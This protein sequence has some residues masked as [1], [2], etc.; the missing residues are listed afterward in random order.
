MADNLFHTLFNNT[1]FSPQVK[2]EPTIKPVVITDEP[3]IA[4][5]AP[6][7]AINELQQTCHHK[8]TPTKFISGTPVVWFCKTCKLIKKLTGETQLELTNRSKGESK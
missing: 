5:E 8:W 3:V 1:D 6:K 7:P 2:T 4:A